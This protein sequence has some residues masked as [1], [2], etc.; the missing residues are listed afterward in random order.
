VPITFV[1]GGF[2]GLIINNN[3]TTVDRIAQ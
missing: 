3:E 1:F 2:G